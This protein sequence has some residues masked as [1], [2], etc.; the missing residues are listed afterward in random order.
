MILSAGFVIG[1]SEH[2][3]LPFKTCFALG[4]GE[5]NV[6]LSF[7]NVPQNYRNRLINHNLC[8]LMPQKPEHV[9]N[10][11][12][13]RLFEV[14]WHLCKC[15]VTARRC[16]FDVGKLCKSGSD[17][18]SEASSKQ[19]IGCTCHCELENCMYCWMHF[20]RDWFFS[21]CYASPMKQCRKIIARCFL[22]TKYYC[23]VVMHMSWYKFKVLFHQ[24][25]KLDGMDI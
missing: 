2:W 3:I 12:G 4:M 22:L 6:I 10:G 16:A 11:P 15:Y 25:E 23:Y 20:I 5:W 7:V 14:C 24:I 8:Y 21:G 9:C 1:G 19:L 13:R 17:D 18:V